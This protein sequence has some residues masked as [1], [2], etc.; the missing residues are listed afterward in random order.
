M[1]FVP[2]CVSLCDIANMVAANLH[3]LVGAV[4]GVV[5]I[6]LFKVCAKGREGPICIG[7]GPINSVNTR[8]LTS[9]GDEPILRWTNDSSV[10]SM[11]VLLH[12]M[13]MRIHRN[14]AFR[15]IGDVHMRCKLS[16]CCVRQNREKKKEDGEELVLLT[17]DFKP[18][19]APFEGVVYLE[20]SDKSVSILFGTNRS[21]KVTLRGQY[22]PITNY[23]CRLDKEEGC[24]IMDRV[25]TLVN[26]KK[27]EGGLG[28]LAKSN[29]K[30]EFLLHDGNEHNGKRKMKKEDNRSPFKFSKATASNHSPKLHTST[31]TSTSSMSRLRTPKQSPNNRQISNSTKKTPSPVQ[32]RIASDDGGRRAHKKS[33]TSSSN[34]KTGTLP[35]PSKPV[36]RRVSPRPTNDSVLGD[37]SSSDDE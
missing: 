12:T 1:V 13:N 16:H 21:K 26:V 18:L 8:V 15:A 2:W 17:Y 36:Y 19:S 23:V 10:R 32:L 30:R 29:T 22:N 34:T 14:L 25:V 3:T 31:S 6:P 24:F 20:E 5:A 28:S 37:S 11:R 7:D 35:Q 9:E 4:H 27:V 33:I